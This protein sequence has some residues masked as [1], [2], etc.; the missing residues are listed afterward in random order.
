MVD[1]QVNTQIKQ[2][3]KGTF[4]KTELTGLG[5]IKSGKVRD[6]YTKDDK[7]IL[8]TS[9]RISSFDVILNQGIPYK[10]QALNQTSEYWFKTT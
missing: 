9:D 8:V 10:G 4:M 3:M 5:E 6:F 7:I 2:N 1:D